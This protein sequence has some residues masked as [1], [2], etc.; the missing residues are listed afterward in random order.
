MPLTHARHRWVRVRTSTALTRRSDPPSV[1]TPPGRLH[2]IPLARHPYRRPHHVRRHYECVRRMRDEVSLSVRNAA[3]DFPLYG[4][5]DALGISRTAL[6][7]RSST[8]APP[9]AAGDSRSPGTL[10]VRSVVRPRVDRGDLGVTCTCRP[11]CSFAR[12]QA[13]AQPITDQYGQER[14]FLTVHFFL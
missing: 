3:S 6:H 7:Q 9:H 12:G 1:S 5:P 8:A 10:R 13:R 11:T 2:P 14:F 4:K